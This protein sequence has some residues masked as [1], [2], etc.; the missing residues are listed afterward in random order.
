MKCGNCDTPLVERELNGV[1]YPSCPTCRCFWPNA[2]KLE[3]VHRYRRPVPV[4][5]TLSLIYEPNNTDHNDLVLRLGT[6]AHRSDTY[7]Y[8]LDHEV[9][10]PA[11]TVRSIR[12]MLIHW[13][14]TVMECGDGQDIYLPHA[15]FDQYSGWL[16][17]SRR[18]DTFQIVDGWSN[19]EGW[20]FYPSEF[21]EKADSMADFQIH[22][23]FGQPVILSLTEIL[24]N[25]D[26][27]LDA[28]E[29]DKQQQ[30]E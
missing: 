27:S 13:R 5:T 19:V 29:L 7:Y 20:S 10:Q 23:D 4:G 28:L 16:R 12:N 18:G 24:A 21:T 22:E 1:S 30:D 25:I 17:C 3:L 8:G 6:W 11:D 15:F 14:D 2:D 26:A 9:N